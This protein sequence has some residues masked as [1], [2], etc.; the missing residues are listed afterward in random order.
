MGELKTKL[1]TIHYERPTGYDSLPQI[2]AELELIK[3]RRQEIA[4]MEHPS[5][6]RTEYVRLSK[7]EAELI[8]LIEF[9][10]MDGSAFRKKVFGCW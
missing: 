1:G 2:K 3:I 8:G 10:Y 6:C 7:R 5:Q 9:K 4:N